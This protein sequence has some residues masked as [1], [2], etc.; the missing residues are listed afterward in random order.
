MDDR[1]H[2]YADIAAIHCLWTSIPLSNRE[3]RFACINRFVFVVAVEVCL[4]DDEG[5]ELSRSIIPLAPTGQVR[6]GP[7]VILL[8]IV[9]DVFNF[10]P[11]II[12]RGVTD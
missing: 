3:I 7:E 4:G 9:Q 2:R 11:S 12:T 6:E 1:F 10:P 8:E 5:H